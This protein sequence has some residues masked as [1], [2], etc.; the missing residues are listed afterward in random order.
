MLQLFQTDFVMNSKFMTMIYV[1]KVSSDVP[2]TRI[3]YFITSVGE[4]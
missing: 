1:D 3:N 4:T 2:A